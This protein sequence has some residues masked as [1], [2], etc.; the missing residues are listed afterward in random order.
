[1]A[2]LRLFTWQTYQLQLFSPLDVAMEK[3]RL[4][5][6]SDFFFFNPV[7]EKSSSLWHKQPGNQ[8]PLVLYSGI[9]KED[10][11]KCH[12]IGEQLPHVWS[13]EFK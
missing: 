4:F 13:F 11:I 9:D 7:A 5:L 10:K 6:N 12:V 1:M 2:L 3:F 8:Q